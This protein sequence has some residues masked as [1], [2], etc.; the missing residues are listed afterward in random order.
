[1]SARASTTEPEYDVAQDDIADRMIDAL[2]GASSL[3]LY[4]LKALRRA[5]SYL[6][7]LSCN[8]RL[9]FSSARS[10][11]DDGVAFRVECEGRNVGSV[12]RFA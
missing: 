8:Q 7:P 1:M 9:Y 2:D 12:A 3:Q 4:Q 5:S 6:S 10:R 11:S